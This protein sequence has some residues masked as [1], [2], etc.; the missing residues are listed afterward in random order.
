MS[1]PL[2]EDW[3]RASLINYGKIRTGKVVC[4]PS[5]G[6]HPNPLPKGEGLGEGYPQILW[7]ADLPGKRRGDD[8]KSISVEDFSWRSPLAS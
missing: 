2:G 1:G 4:V 5:L 7:R 8:P 3:L 6:P